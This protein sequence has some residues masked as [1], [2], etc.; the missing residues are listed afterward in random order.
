MRKEPTSAPPP[1][2]EDDG[3]PDRSKS[4]YLL[5]G[6]VAAAVLA[7]D[8]I[9]KQL[10]LDNLTA[11]VDVIEGVF[12][13][14]LAFNSGGA[15]GL[16]RGLPG[17]FLIATTV[18]IALIVFWVRSLEDP[19]WVVP[20]GLILG[21][22]LGNLA[23]RVLRDLD[24]GVVDFLDFHVWPVFNLADSAIVV[25]VLTIFWFSFRSERDAKP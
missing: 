10:A 13:L 16:L 23:D 22:G 18:V 25:G 11:P 3:A 20:L 21:G 19:R 2:A 6:V 7:V 15:F 9:T 8:Q 14:R 1:G 17:F 5:L 4:P 24:G 12:R